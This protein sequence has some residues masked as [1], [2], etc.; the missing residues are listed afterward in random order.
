MDASL[1]SL[2]LLKAVRLCMAV[3]AS[4]TFADHL[5]ASAGAVWR[6]LNSTRPALPLTVPSPLRPPWFGGPSAAAQLVFSSSATVYGIPERVPL[7]E[8][9]PLSAINPVSPPRA[10]RA[11]PPQTGDL[12][13]LG[14]RPKPCSLLLMPEALAPDVGSPWT[15]PRP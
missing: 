10:W 11:Q 8:D 9:C 1:L 4:G 2:P 3:S 14:W 12:A 6:L 5:T 15:S 7:T 13:L